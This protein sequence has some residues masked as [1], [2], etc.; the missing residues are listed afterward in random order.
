MN[1]YDIYIYTIFF[2]KLVMILSALLYYIL[3]KTNAKHDI[4]NKIKNIKNMFEF[5]FVFL[6]SILLIYIFTPFNPK[7]INYETRLLFF[8]LGIILLI[9]AKYG[10]FFSDSKNVLE[11]SRIQ[12]IFG[13]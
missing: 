11:F 9:T 8:L 1:G 12:Q 4:K 2:C 6:M 10:I 5:L 7:V 13:N 3:N